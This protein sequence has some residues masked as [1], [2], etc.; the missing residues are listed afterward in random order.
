MT[1]DHSTLSIYPATPAQI[2]E[3]RR[4]TW[5][6]WGKGLTLQEHLA[7]DAA[8]DLLEGSRDGRLITWVLAPR[9]N[10]QTLDFKCSCETFK[11]TALVVNPASASVET[12]T[13]YAIASVFTPPENRGQGF[14]RHM[15]RLMHWVVAD[16]ALL[17]SGDFPAVWGEPPCKV[18]GLR[19]GRFSTLWSDVGDFYSTCGPVPG[20]QDGWT[21][22]G[23]STTAWDLDA[24]SFPDSTAGDSTAGDWTWLDDC[25]VVKLWEED[26]EKIRRDV[27]QIHAGLTFTCLPSHGVASFQHRS[28]DIFSDRLDNP[29]RIWGVVSPDRS[30]YA[31]W[32][33]DPRPPAPRTLTVSR[34]RV[35]PSDF[36][37]LLGRVFEIAKK[38]DV[39]R[40][41]IWSLPSELEV[42]ARQLG[43]TTYL[44]E[45]HLPAFKWYGKEREADVSWAF[46]ERF[47]WC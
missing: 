45:E 32:M 4:R 47:G 38:Y 12:V 30:T 9:D 14:A 15:M 25:G 16:E 8:Q 28:L 7:S 46:N 29:L 23:R 20:T 40:I 1:V 35:E 17:P 21:I 37:A 33:M 19:N 22:R 43:A 2:S 39:E 36:D 3:A 31:T 6:E 24:C 26:S 13:C 34:L 18:N 11:R 42:V 44:R 41:E 5:S 10:S 27:E